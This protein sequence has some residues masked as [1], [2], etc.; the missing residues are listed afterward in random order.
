[1]PRRVRSLGELHRD[2]PVRADALIWGRRADPRTRRGFLYSSGL[3]A[4]A[5]DGLRDGVVPVLAVLQ[6]PYDVVR[7][8]IADLTGL[9]GMAAENRRLREENRRLM[10]RDAEAAWLA[11][12]NRSLRRMLAVPEVPGHPPRL[13]ARIVGDSG[14]TF[15][16]AL[17]LDAGSEQGVS[18]GMP[19]LAPEGLVGRVVERH[20]FRISVGSEPS[21]LRDEY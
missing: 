21:A 8:G 12:E 19:A 16:R 11:A 10:A 17:L 1:M 18:V 14:G 9:L 15:V 7:D 4:M 20:G 3:T 5:G 2:D 13:T 6:R